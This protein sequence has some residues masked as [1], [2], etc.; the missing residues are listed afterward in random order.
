[1]SETI[2]VSL[3]K[4]KTHEFKRTLRYLQR[5]GKT[6]HEAYIRLGE[7]QQEATKRLTKTGSAILILYLI[8]SSLREGTLVSITFQNITASVPAAYLLAVSSIWIFVF[9]QQSL[10]VWML[11]EIRAFVSVQP[12]LPGFS[13]SM[14]G[15]IYGQD[16]MS[17]VLPLFSNHFLREKLPV[18][19]ALG[20][21]SLV[22]YSAL[23]I[24]VLAFSL[25][26]SHFQISL[27]L[28]ESI[29]FLEKSAAVLGLLTLV[30][31]AVFLFLF[32]IPMPMRK[33]IYS[34][35]F[36]VLIWL[37]PLGR[38]PQTIKW[39]SESANKKR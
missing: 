31:C 20:I 26:V 7:M 8:L 16:E 19:G 38:H 15:F 11:I 36:R 1:M 18:S 9:M 17:L 25:Y 35:R 22:V 27:L 30:S 3:R 28:T 2:Y 34:I 21:L 37:S 24:P 10:I 14:H 33:D 5:A 13:A 12:R 29:P 39:L 6:W 23:L 4:L 32:N